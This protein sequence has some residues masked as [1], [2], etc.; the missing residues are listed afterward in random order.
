MTDNSSLVHYELYSLPEGALVYQLKPEYRT[1]QP[2]HYLCAHCY[3]KD[4]KSI[5]NPIPPVSGFKMMR[6]PEC[7]VEIMSEK[8]PTASFVIKSQ[9][10][11]FQDY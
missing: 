6:C 7:H 3:L 4:I 2:E 10:R 5:L 11:R 8:I 9:P 1:T